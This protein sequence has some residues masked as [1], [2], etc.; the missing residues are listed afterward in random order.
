MHIHP[1]RSERGGTAMHMCAMRLLAQ[2]SDGVDGFRSRLDWSLGSRSMK[3]I[4]NVEK[5][6]L[7]DSFKIRIA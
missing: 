2:E 7:A 1:K 6:L 3:I 4:N 5:P